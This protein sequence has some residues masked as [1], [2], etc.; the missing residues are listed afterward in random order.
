MEKAGLP[1]T[2]GAAERG[3]E[4]RST[5]EV[6]ASAATVT[7]A[8][9]RALQAAGSARPCAGAQAPLQDQTSI[10]IFPWA[11]PSPRYRK[12]SAVSLSG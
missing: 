6:M 11:C 1:V 3:V 7:A 4:M 12:A 5:G 8:Y 10:T 2:A 9:R